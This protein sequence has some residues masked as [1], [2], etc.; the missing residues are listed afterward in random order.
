MGSGGLM[1]RAVGLAPRSALLPGGWV[2]PGCQGRQVPT[3]GCGIG[4]GVG[5][6]VSIFTPFIPPCSPQ[7]AAA[8]AP[9]LS[10]AGCRSW[11]GR[12]GGTGDQDSDPAAAALSLFFFWGGEGG[13]R[14]GSPFWGAGGW[15][16]RSR[17]AGWWK[18]FLGERG[19]S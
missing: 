17:E 9:G 2:L 12:G 4:I 1:G 11:Q 18:P 7:P 14:V 8:S 6:V 15:E 3:G 16:S 5:A 13:G 19:G 10:L